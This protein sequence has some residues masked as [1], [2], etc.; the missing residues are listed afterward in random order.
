MRSMRNITNL[1][2]APR[3]SL[4][5]SAP[6]SAPQVVKAGISLAKL[7]ADRLLM[8]DYDVKR[9]DASATTTGGMVG[10]HV[11]NCIRLVGLRSELELAA[12]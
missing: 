10:S 4:V 9:I 1:N 8:F 11:L 6:R 2:F 5:T 3:S 7:Q 12:L